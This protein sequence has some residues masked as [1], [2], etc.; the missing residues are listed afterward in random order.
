M[1]DV[2]IRH[3]TAGDREAVE[4][5]LLAAFPTSLEHRLVR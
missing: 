2:R 1:T 4:G 3:E 5:L